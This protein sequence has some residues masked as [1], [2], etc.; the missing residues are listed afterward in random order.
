MF[1]PE[2]DWNDA[3]PQNIPA[4]TYW[5]VVLAMGLTFIFWGFVTIFIISVVGGILF[6]IALAGWIKELREYV[7][8]NSKKSSHGS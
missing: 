3:T 2:E 1:Q 8:T 5:P 4:A 6:S 7:I